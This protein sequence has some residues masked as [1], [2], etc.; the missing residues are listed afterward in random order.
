M[1]LQD[2]PTDL[3]LEIGDHLDPASHLRLRL[4]CRTFHSRL[5]PKLPAPNEVPGFLTT[6]ESWPENRPLLACQT[7][8]KLLP[9]SSFAP[10]QRSGW[11]AKHGK[12]TFMRFCIACGYQRGIY[13][14]KSSGPGFRQDAQAWIYCIVC[15]SNVNGGSCQ[16]CKCCEM[17][18][19]LVP[20]AVD[21][22]DVR[23][24][25]RGLWRNCAHGVPGELGRGEGS[26]G[27]G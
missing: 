9:T 27:W 17:C 2:L 13:A 8:L 18:L 14:Q 24:E 7:C 26:W 1:N 3:L 12:D 20:A 19:R 5:P 15:H 4:C 25:G 21:V 10:K 16:Q 11:R 6:L 23:A 22:G